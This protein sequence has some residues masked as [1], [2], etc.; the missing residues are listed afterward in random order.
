MEVINKLDELELQRKQR[1]VLDALVS[2]YPRFVTAADLEQ[3]MWEDVGEAVPQSPTAI[4]THV[5]KLRKR[6]RGLGFGIEAKR[7]VG[8]RLTLKSTNGGQ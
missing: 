4:A 8:L 5:S 2:S 3:W 7:F 6:L 1:A